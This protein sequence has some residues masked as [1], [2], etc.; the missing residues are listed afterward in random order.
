M[1]NTLGTLAATGVFHDALGLILKRL[2]MVT[3]LAS[4][5]ADIYGEVNTPFNVAQ[6][7]KDYNATIGV[8]DVSSTGTYAIQSGQ[9]ITLPSD[10]SLTLDKWK[11][12]GFKLSLAEINTLVDSATNKDAR[13]TAV[14]KLMTR[15]FNKMETNIYTEFLSIITAGNYAQTA[16]VSGV[17]TADYKTL[18]GI[19]DTL[20]QRDALDAPNAILGIPMFREV[21]N[22]L[23]NIANASVNIS[24][25]VETAEINTPLSGCKSVRRYKIGRAHV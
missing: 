2:P 16:Y 13:A 18:A 8:N 17:G 11:A 25:T 23:T 7:L 4:N 21:A 9:G 10:K 19:A 20:L 12:F 24:D 15:A 3:G 5:M 14:Q 22:S 1:S 6:I